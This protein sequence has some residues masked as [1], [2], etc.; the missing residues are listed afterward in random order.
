[1][2]G[3]LVPGEH[4]V[5]IKP[6]CSDLIEKLNYYDEHPAEARAIVENAHEYCRQF[7]NK[8]QES[9]ISLMVMERYFRM[10][11]QME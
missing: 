7:F 5:S 2:E 8:A 10:T 3:R 11:G 4:F 6:D 9:L 1:M